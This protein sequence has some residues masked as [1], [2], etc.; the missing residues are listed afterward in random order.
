[1]HTSRPQPVRPLSLLDLGSLLF[2][3]AVWGGAF[4]FLRIA[5]P[6]IG[7]VWAAEIRLAVGA[8]TLVVFA[9]RRTLAVV[10][11]R[12]VGFLV[13]GTMF[14]AVPFSL[15]AYATLTLPTGFAALLNASTP[16]FT[17]VLGV[18][19]LRQRLPLR[20]VGGLAAGA[21]A[22]LV[23][24][25]WSPLEPGVGTLLAVLA[26]LAAAASYA[27]AG[28]YVRARMH[29]VGGIELATGM[30]V[31]GVV[32]LLPFAVAS[33]A[34]GTP[35][36]AGVA[37]LVLVGV[38]STAVA[39]PVFFR[40]LAHTTPTAASTVTFIVPAFALAWGALALGERVGP[41]LIGG[42]VLVML[43]LVLVLGLRPSL[44]GGIARLVPRLS[45]AAA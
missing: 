43:S 33:G 9:G 39:W 23:L 31:A 18:V 36:L 40:V 4:L 29:G 34:P 21:V 37:S 11:G 41:E 24:V 44:P 6:E 35:S 42:F 14:A 28:T 15:I 17:A 3:G 20:A 45:R 25:G 30:L 10:R 16:L 5:S 2:L 38:V 12:V 1:M 7:P 13:V 32:V 19:V 26:A 8:I 22:V 27:L